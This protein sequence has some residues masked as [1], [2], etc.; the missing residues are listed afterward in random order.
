[1]TRTLG[2]AARKIRRL[3]E[4]LITGSSEL[5]NIEQTSAQAGGPHLARVN[6]IVILWNIHAKNPQIVL[7]RPKKKS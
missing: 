2:S 5:E 3:E 4:E 7:Q 1:M 6:I